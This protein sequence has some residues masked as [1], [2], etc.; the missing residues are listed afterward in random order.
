MQIASTDAEKFTAY[1]IMLAIL[2]VVGPTLTASERIGVVNRIIAGRRLAQETIIAN[3][4][5]DIE[6]ARTVLAL[7]SSDEAVIGL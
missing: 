6:R 1:F 5:H 4:E 3:T 7:M 2:P